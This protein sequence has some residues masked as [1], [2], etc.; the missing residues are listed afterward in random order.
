L[1]A[2]RHEVTAVRLYDPLELELPD[3]GLV[4]MQDA[5]TGEQL[6][7]DTRDGGFRRRF[8]EGAAR[9]ELA[10]RR[11]LVEAGVD[12]LE[13]ATDDEL[14]AALMRFAMLRKRRSQLAGG[15]VPAR[16]SGASP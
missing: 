14:L 5:E 15:G 1:L 4:P 10:L 12:C 9:R 13:L 6:L 3:L 2:R 11:A 7:V 16:V 8:A